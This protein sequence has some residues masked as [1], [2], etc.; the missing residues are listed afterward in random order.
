MTIDM[1]YD[2]WIAEVNIAVQLMTDG[3][4][5]H[6]LVDYNYRALYDEGLNPAEAAEMIVENDGTFG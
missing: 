3:F 6:D 5:I 1:S 2:A 4:S